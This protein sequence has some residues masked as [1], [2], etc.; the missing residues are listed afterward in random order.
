ML[1][2]WTGGNH[3]N[4]T[5]VTEN[6]HRTTATDN[7]GYGSFKWNSLFPPAVK[8]RLVGTNSHQTKC[9]LTDR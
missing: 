1:T 6:T 9:H 7:K 2:V 4:V 3:H 8:E 5:T